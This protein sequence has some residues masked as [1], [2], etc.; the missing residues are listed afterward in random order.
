MGKKA[1]TEAERLDEAQTAPE[2]VGEGAAQAE[3]TPPEAPEAVGEGAAQA[4]STPP[5]A[6]EAEPPA[7][8]PDEKISVT[9]RHKTEYPRYRRAG[10]ILKQTPG[11]FSVTAEQLEILKKDKWVEVGEK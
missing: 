4:E 11:E 6:P 10:L 9:L 1:N 3:S 8:G 2:A 7:S 5:E